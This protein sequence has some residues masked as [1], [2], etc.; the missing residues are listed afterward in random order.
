METLSGTRNSNMGFS[1]DNALPALKV[2]KV[3]L[4]RW[5][6]KESGAKKDEIP[7]EVYG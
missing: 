2:P 1:T 4:L 6:L 3:P 7:V 5:Q